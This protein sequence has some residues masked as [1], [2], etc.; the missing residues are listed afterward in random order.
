MYSRYFMYE[1][2]AEYM[3]TKTYYRTCPFCGCNLD[4]GERCDCGDERK[5]VKNHVIIR[6][7]NDGLQYVQASPP[8]GRLRRIYNNVDGKHIQSG[9]HF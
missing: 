7:G 2:Q 3:G 5:E 9:N 6:P 8:P 1:R 4:P